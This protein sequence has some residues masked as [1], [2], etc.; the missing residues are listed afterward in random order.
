LNS[1]DAWSRFLG[2]PTWLQE[3]LQHVRTACRHHHVQTC[4]RSDIHKILT[5]QH[6][7]S[8]WEQEEVVLQEWPRKTISDK[9][10]RIL[11]QNITCRCLRRE[12]WFS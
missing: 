2:N 9:C 8:L 1:P 3:T 12:L 10:K 11:K 5:K 7:N 6:N 4:C